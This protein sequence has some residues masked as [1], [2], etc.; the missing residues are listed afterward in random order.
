MAISVG[1]PLINAIML[2]YFSDVPLLISGPHGVGKSESYEQAAK[3]LGI[4]IKIFDLSVMEP[5]DLIGLPK[6]DN[7]KTSYNPPSSLPTEGKGLLIIEELNR[8]PRYMCA[9]CFQ[10]MTARCLGTDY[11]L[12]K[13]W[14]PVVAIN[15]DEGEYQVEALDPAL[16]SRFSRVEVYPC[17]RE[18]LK[19]APANDIDPQVISFVQNMPNIFSATC[20]RSLT[21][22]SNILK[23]AGNSRTPQSVV[24]PLVAGLIGDDLAH[25]LLEGSNNMLL[26]LTDILTGY[27]KHQKTVRALAKEGRLD[28]LRSLANSLVLHIQK[29]EA[30]GKKLPK[31]QMERFNLFLKDLPGDLADEFA[32]AMCHE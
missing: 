7:N 18:W 6:I 28:S 4:D 13:G 27:S 14:L 32:E 16:L 20:P 17:V 26:Q 19:W 9:P 31:A 23:T 10:L 21:Y 24:F 15:P 11:L 2:A 29:I 22:V 12:P 5:P 30:A 1:E 3:R 25:A 8:C